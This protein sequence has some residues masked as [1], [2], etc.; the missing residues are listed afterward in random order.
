MKA[1]RLLT[2]LRKR[3]G[4]AVGA[5][6]L[7]LTVLISDHLDFNAASLMAGWENFVIIWGE[8]MP[9]DFDKVLFE[10]ASWSHPRCESS[11]DWVCS[12]A[13]NGLLQTI[14][15]AFL[16]TFFGMILALPLSMAA[17]R[18][19]SPEWLSDL[20]RAILAGLRVL[21]SLVWALIFVIIVGVGPLAGVL[22]MTLYTIGYLGKLQYEAFEGVDPHPLEAARAMGLSRWRVARFFAL[23][24]AANALLSQM[25]FMFEYNVRHG[26]VI[27]LVGAGGIGWYMSYYLDPFKLYDRVTALLIIMYVAVLIID[28]I[29]LRLRARFIET[30]HAQKASWMGVF[31]PWNRN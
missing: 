6:L 14:E 30:E 17:A 27:G 8:A 18:N 4:Y 1:V 11:W 12:P 29:S 20:S 10:R 25:L 13:V 2:L 7:A 26:S 15:I 23:P 31:L 22:A 16:A 24:E 28:R 21:P 9:P 19:L 3:P 5:L